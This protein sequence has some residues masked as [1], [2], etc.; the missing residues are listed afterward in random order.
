VKNS[1]PVEKSNELAVKW[2]VETTTDPL[3]APRRAW[4]KT[5]NCDALLD[6]L[7]ICRHALPPWLGDALEAAV[8]EWSRSART[9]KKRGR[10]TRAATAR[11]QQARDL[12]Q[13]SFYR[14]QCANGRSP[15]EAKAMT[16]DVFQCSE[17]TISNSLARV[18]RMTPEERYLGPDDRTEQWWYRLLNAPGYAEEL[19]RLRELSE[20]YRPRP[21]AR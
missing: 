21:K 11:R 7:R 16:A 13:E 8:V 19:R 14:M 12:A 17:R 4:E 10:H 9:G 5:G 2:R 6:A 20:Q 3:E 18:K 1:R 15:D